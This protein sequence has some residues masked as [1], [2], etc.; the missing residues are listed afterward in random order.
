[1]KYLTNETIAGISNKLYSLF[2]ENY[3]IYTEEIKQDLKKPC[4]YIVNLSVRNRVSLGLRYNHE[5]SFDIHFFPGKSG[6]Q[7]EMSEIADKLMTN[8]TFIQV[9]DKSY[10]YGSNINSQIVE[11]VL[12]VFVNYDVPMKIVKTDNEYMNNLEINGGMKYGN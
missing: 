12:H 10:L 9:Q 1:V 5:Q 6:S 7:S 4:F 11:D 2:G 8:L 3:K